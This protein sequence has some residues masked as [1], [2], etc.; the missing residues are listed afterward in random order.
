MIIELSASGRLPMQ[1]LILLVADT[2]MLI[3]ILSGW[4]FETEGFF[5]IVR[6]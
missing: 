4:G 6:Q 1:D 3:A 5:C 2:Q